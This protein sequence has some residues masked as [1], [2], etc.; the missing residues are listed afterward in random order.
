MKKR[1]LLGCFHPTL[2]R[3]AKEVSVSEETS[4]LI[5]EM[6]EI[7]K[8]EKGVGLAAP[9]IGVSKRVILVD[10]GQEIFALLNPQIVWGSKEKIKT[11]EGCLSVRGVWYDVLRPRKV[12]VRGVTEEGKDIEIEAEDLMAVIFQHEID[13]LNGKLFIDNASFFTKI[14]LFSSY[15]YKNYARSS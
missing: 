5:K 8:E 3:K 7:L 10:T 1:K 2:R 14:K 11:K 15:I 12:K 4:S 13:H 6:R 9:Q